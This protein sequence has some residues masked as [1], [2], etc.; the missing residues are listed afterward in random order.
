MS[1]LCVS[2]CFGTFQSHTQHNTCG[3]ETGF[4]PGNLNSILYHVL[5][6]KHLLSARTF[7]TIL[8]IQSSAL[9]SHYSTLTKYLPLITGPNLCSIPFSDTKFSSLGTSSFKS[10]VETQIHPALTCPHRHDNT[11]SSCEE[12]FVNALICSQYLFHVYPIAH[13]AWCW[14]PF[15][16]QNQGS[17]FQNIRTIILL[18]SSLSCF[19]SSSSFYQSAVPAFLF[20]LFQHNTLVTSLFQLHHLYHA[21]PQFSLSFSFSDSIKSKSAALN[22]K[23]SLVQSLSLKIVSPFQHLHSRAEIQFSIRALL[24]LAWRMKQM[25]PNIHSPQIFHGGRKGLFLLECMLKQESAP[26]RLS[27]YLSEIK[28]TIIHFKWHC[29]VK[30]CKE[31]FKISKKEL[32]EVWCLWCSPLETIFPLMIFPSQTIYC[33]SYH[34]YSHLVC[35]SLLSIF[36]ISYKKIFSKYSDSLGSDLMDLTSK[37]SYSYHLKIVTVYPTTNTC[38]SKVREELRAYEMYMY[39]RGTAKSTGKKTRGI[40]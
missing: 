6:L 12:H 19:T 7:T 9:T 26:T 30:S 25:L 16:A 33:E 10:L 3:P 15:D 8:L 21:Q 24:E 29:L 37:M 11:S 32:W 23:S 36:G 5:Y 34:F 1:F 2:E 39:D 38:V 18:S 31:K 27:T 35:I 40:E 14:V 13:E 4:K 17:L 22:L 28:M 20:L